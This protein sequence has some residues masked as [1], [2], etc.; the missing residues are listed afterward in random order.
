MFFYKYGL[1]APGPEGPFSLRSLTKRKNFPEP[2]RVWANEKAPRLDLGAYRFTPIYPPAFGWLIASL[3]A[4]RGRKA[5][6]GIYF[7]FIIL[8]I[9]SDFSTCWSGEI[10]SSA[11]DM[12]AA[13]L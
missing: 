1:S 13:I 8:T 11:E 2:L 10:L 12:T 9:S 6:V 4:A 7:P 3:T 5:G